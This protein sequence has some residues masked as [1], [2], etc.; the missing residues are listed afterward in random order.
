MCAEV[1][2]HFGELVLAFH[3]VE[4][5]S[6]LFLLLPNIPQASWLLGDCLNPS[7]RHRSAGTLV[8]CSHIFM[9]VHGIQLGVNLAFQVLHMLICL[10]GLP[11]L[12]YF[13][14]FFVC[15]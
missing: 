13:W 8:T 5:G 2:G 10:L 11:R 1:R 3:F 9:C 4:K 12:S 6:L 7:S 15:F 14:F